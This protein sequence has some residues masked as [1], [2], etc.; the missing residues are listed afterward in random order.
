MNVCV[1]V[2]VIT[3]A[4]WQTYICICVCRT[5]QETLSEG[6]SFA[7]QTFLE[8]M[9]PLARAHWPH[10]VLR[11]T[12]P[13][14]CPELKT[15]ATITTM[16]G[17]KLPKKTDARHYE[18]GKVLSFPST[19][20]VG[21]LLP[22]F[23][24]SIKNVSYFFSYFMKCNLSGLQYKKI[25]GRFQK[26]WLYAWVDISRGKWENIDSGEHCAY[27]MLSLVEVSRII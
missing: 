16:F 1:V 12:H 20:S 26:A 19:V 17:E 23:F 4:W 6:W 24:N 3:A 7:P 13:P 25:N 14:F 2:V 5:E 21:I 22:H 27:I 18:K 8:S 11:A 10:R 15:A 9:W